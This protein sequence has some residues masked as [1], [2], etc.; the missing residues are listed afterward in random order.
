MTF[1][2][3]YGSRLATSL[4]VLLL[5]GGSARCGAGSGDCVQGLCVI[6]QDVDLAA[7]ILTSALYAERICMV[8]DALET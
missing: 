6:G 4:F 2:R 8:S 5:A 7:L 3:R 1:T